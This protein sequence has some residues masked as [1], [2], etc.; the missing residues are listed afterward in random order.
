[1]SFDRFWVCTTADRATWTERRQAERQARRAEFDAELAR[2]QKQ[3]HVVGANYSFD[4]LYVFEREADPDDIGRAFDDFFEESGTEPVS[5]ATIQ[6]ASKETGMPIT[7]VEQLIADGE[8]RSFA[9]VGECPDGSRP[10]I[11]I[12]FVALPDVKAA[13]ERCRQNA[14]S[15]MEAAAPWKQWIN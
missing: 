8:A 5:L 14:Q 9:A 6:A 3:G 12:L 4:E 7:L 15:T 11:E 1:M 13:A 10:P 2:L